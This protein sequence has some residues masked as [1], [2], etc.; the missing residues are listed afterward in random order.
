MIA[1]GIDSVDISRFKDW[2]KYPKNQLSKI[3][4]EKEIDYCLSNILKSAERFSAR[5]A[6]KEALFK[7]LTQY[8]KKH[9]NFLELCKNSEITHNKLG[10]PEFIINWEKISSISGHIPAVNCSISHSKN[11]SICIVIVG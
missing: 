8:L 11:I 4:S 10:A 7:A 3:F 5:F 1:V 9:I 2:H 6:A